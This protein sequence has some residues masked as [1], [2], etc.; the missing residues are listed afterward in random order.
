MSKPKTMTLR[1]DE[2]R[3]EALEGL[4]EHVGGGTTSKAIWQAIQN[5]PAQAEA[6]RVER[7][8]LTDLRQKVD[9]QAAALADLRR[10][11]DRAADFMRSIVED[12]CELFYFPRTDTDDTQ[13]LAALVDALETC[14]WR[15]L[16]QARGRSTLSV[17]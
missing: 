11:S 3:A 7:E 13:A 17:R 16:S 10:W 9:R 4:L 14:G 8:A 6:L 1:I 5:Y 2:A 15:N 12:D